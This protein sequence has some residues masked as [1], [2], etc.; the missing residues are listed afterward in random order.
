MTGLYNAVTSRESVITL[1]VFFPLLLGGL[2]VLNWWSRWVFAAFGCC[3]RDYPCSFQHA[4]RVGLLRVARGEEW[5]CL[6]TSFEVLTRLSWVCS[7]HAC[8]RLNL[9]RP[10]VL[11]SVAL[12]WVN[13]MTS[14][15][16]YHLNCA[17]YDKNAFNLVTYILCNF[18]SHAF[19]W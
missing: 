8:Q 2:A 19:C 13:V 15:P 9:P 1:F 5:W 11:S 17:W 3:Q 18:I 14:W 4:T 12:W 10:N 16:L 7:E 6:W